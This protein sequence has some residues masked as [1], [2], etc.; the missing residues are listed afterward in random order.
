MEVLLALRTVLAGDD[1]FIRVRHGRPL[2]EVKQEIIDAGEVD[3]MQGL[4][5]RTIRGCVDLTDDAVEGPNET[6]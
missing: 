6:D 5:F 4:V 2:V 1:E 3:E